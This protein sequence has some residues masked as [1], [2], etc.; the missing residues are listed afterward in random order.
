[1]TASAI[2]AA[3]T[4]IPGLIVGFISWAAAAG[5]AAIAT[6][7]ATWPILLV[8]AGIALLIAGIV[9][10]ITHWKQVSDFALMIWGHIRQFF[11]DDVVKPIGNLFNDLGTNVHNI[12]NNIG[13]FFSGLGSTVHKV[14]GGI[15]DAFSGLGKLVHGIWDGITGAIKGAIN[16]VIGLINNVIGAIDN[17]HV[18]TPFGSIGF[19]IPKIP[20][21]AQGGEV[22]PGKAAIAGETGQPELVLG[23]SHGATVLGVSQTASLLAGGGSKQ[24]IYVLFQVDGKTLAGGMLP[25]LANGIINATR[26]G[27]PIGQVA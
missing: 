19:N 3:V 1:M 8:V 9:L 20:L 21:L 5:A 4:A 22:A 14:I 10:L 27:H 26:S 23:G 12:L 17:I 15:G 16:F 11:E 7:A 6:I 24:P 18:N 2:T 25:E 13:N